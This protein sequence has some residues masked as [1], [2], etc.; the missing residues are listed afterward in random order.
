MKILDIEIADIQPESARVLDIGCG[1][2]W[3]VFDAAK[4]GANAYGLDLSTELLL[5]ARGHQARIPVEL[6][7]F[8]VLGDS[9]NAPFAPAV[10]DL[11]ICTELIEHTT[12]T[13]ATL[14]EIQRVLKPGGWLVL[15]FPVKYVEKVIVRFSKAFLEYSGH[16]RQFTL[17]EMGI[18]LGHHGLRVVQTHRRFFEWSFYWLMRS[19]LHQVPSH[20]RQFDRYGIDAPED[21]KWERFEYYYKRVW[22][23]SVQWK[24]GICLLWLGNLIFP[25]SYVLICRQIDR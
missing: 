21:I 17:R 12:E 20:D 23:K 6:Q 14:A 19:V 24:F 4:Q 5:K 3:A 8:F 15:S 18:F 2:G 25:K 13:D 16:V 1:Q 10:F 22:A 7:S 11:I 9:A